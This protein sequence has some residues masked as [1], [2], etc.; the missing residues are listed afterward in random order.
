MKKSVLIALTLLSLLTWRSYAQTIQISQNSPPPTESSVIQQ[1]LDLGLL[2]AQRN[3]WKDRSDSFEQAAKQIEKRLQDLEQSLK[4]SPDPQILQEEIASL[5]QQLSEARDSLKAS[6]GTSDTLDQKIKD[7]QGVI[8]KAEADHK[9]EVNS[10]NVRLHIWRGAA[11]VSAGAA[12]GAILGKGDLATTGIG[13][14]AGLAL[15][16]I[17]EVF[18]L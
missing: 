10:M 13:A 17:L 7:Q 15:D 14:G 2:I 8:D 6:H 11:L 5:R 4:D 1:R 3:Y 12:G 16:L 18:G 9:A